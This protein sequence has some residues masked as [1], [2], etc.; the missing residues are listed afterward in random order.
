MKKTNLILSLVAALF[1]TTGI[2]CGGDSNSP[3]PPVNPD[4]NAGWQAGQK[5][6][7]YYASEMDGIGVMSD[8]DELAGKS[9]FVFIHS[10][11]M[12]ALLAHCRETGMK[13]VVSLGWLTFDEN[14]RLYPDWQDRLTFATDIMDKY[15]DVIIANYILDE[16]FMNGAKH[17]VSVDEMYQYLESV[18]QFFKARYP[19]MPLA[20]I[21]SGD[22]LN[23]G[24]R[25][26]PS[27][28]WFG[29]DCYDGFSSCGGRS[30][31]DFYQLI[32]NELYQLEAIDHR[33]RQ[34]MAVPPAG[35]EQNNA[36]KQSL[37]LSQ[38]AQYRAWI[39]SEKR[40][41]IVMPFIWQTF[42]SA[43][44]GGWYGARNSESL[45]STYVQMYQDFMNGTL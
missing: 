2:S 12:R 40:V 33:S 41:T 37:H 23:K 32:K 29:M 43:S 13:A 39:K 21:F 26:P 11:D 9:N 6:F 18:G 38:V 1:L 45:K 14:M 8:I 19:A 30:I 4:P 15:Q 10:G 16:P 5:Y 36:S 20:V 34:L 35:W 31:P 25:V 27:F 22:E 17:G 3:P 42:G 28:D 7:G 44:D 24:F